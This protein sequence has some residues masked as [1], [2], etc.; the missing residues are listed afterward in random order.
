M[1]NDAFLAVL[2]AALMNA[3]W[4]SAI[5]LGGDKVVVMALT[6]LF[7]SVASFV[8]LPFIGISAATSWGLLALSIA[9][10]TIYHFV[11]AFA[12]RHGDLGHVYPIARGGAPLFVTLAAAAFLFELPSFLEVFG[13]ACLCAGVLAFA[14]GHRTG[15]NGR[16]GTAY[17]LA[18]SVMIASYTVIDGLGARNSASALQ[19]GVLLTIGDGVATALIVL[20]WKGK[21]AFYSVDS[22]TLFLS[23]LAGIMQIGAYWI[24]LWA[25]A[26]APLGAVS[27]LRESSVLFVTLIS[28]FLLKERLGMQRIACAS[29]VFVGIILVKIGQ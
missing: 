27:A 22:T 13:I 7:G 29:L 12:Y 20:M 3:V 24:A 8:A 2:L 9:L 21:S 28:T 16:L 14:L 23:S 19:F 10:H 18:T 6:T 4:N 25:L 15:E 5:K 26:R 17:A 1:T 11:L